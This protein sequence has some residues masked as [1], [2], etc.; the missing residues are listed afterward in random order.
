[1]DKKET[2]KNKLQKKKITATTTTSEK[3]DSKRHTKY[4]N[5]HTHSQIMYYMQTD[6]YT[7]GRTD[8]PTYQLTKPKR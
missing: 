6:K 4:T 1:M 3:N 7:D 2:M 5:K 8:R